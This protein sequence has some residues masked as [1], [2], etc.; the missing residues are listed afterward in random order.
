MIDI[1]D[2]DAEELFVISRQ[3]TCI[4]NPYNGKTA[5]YQIF[6]GENAISKN[7]ATCSDFK[8]IKI[9]PG[10]YYLVLM[11]ATSGDPET[12]KFEAFYH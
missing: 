7:I 12:V 4:Q 6:S 9:K 1:T 8:S 5:G 2:E 11:G 10:K 3:M